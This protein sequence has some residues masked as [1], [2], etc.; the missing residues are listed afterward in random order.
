MEYLVKT[1]D[2]GKYYVSK[3][4]ISTIRETCPNCGSWDNIILSYEDGEK[5]IT[6]EEYFSKIHN[7]TISIIN[8]TDAGLTK[9]DI[10]TCSIFHFGRKK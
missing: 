1:H 8:S 7:D 6:L 9:K 2:T 4:P 5:D 10:I 3:D